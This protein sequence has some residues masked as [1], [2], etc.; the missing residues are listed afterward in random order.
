MRGLAT[1]IILV[2][3]VVFLSCKKDTS[4]TDQKSLASSIIGTWE[5]RQ[6]SAAM[7]PLATNYAPGNGNLLR[8]TEDKKYEVYRNG[9]LTKRGSYAIAEDTSVEQN[10]CL[11]FPDGMFSNRIDY[12][13]SVLVFKQFIQVDADTLTIVAGCYAIDAGHQAKYLRQDKVVQF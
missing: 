12:Q 8:F 1:V 5:L 4:A 2:F 7:N 3:L 13:D 9:N 10:V 11:V 6:T